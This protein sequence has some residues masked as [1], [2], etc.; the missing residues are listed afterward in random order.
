MYCKHFQEFVDILTREVVTEATTIPFSKYSQIIFL[1]GGAGSGKNFALNHLL[2]ANGRNLDVDDFKDFLTGEKVKNPD[3][4][5]K[6]KEFTIGSLTRK[7]KE[8][9]EKKK[10]AS[11]ADIQKIEDMV[12]ATNT[13]LSYLQN[14]K[15]LTLSDP[16]NVTILH[17]VA[18]VMFGYGDI[19]NRVAAALRSAYLQKDKSRLGNLVFNITGKDVKDIE[20]LAI[21][22]NSVGYAPE[23]THIV[24]VLDKIDNARIKNS[25]RPR[26]VSDAV[27]K[28]TH[29]GANDTMEMIRKDFDKLNLRKYVDGRVIILFNQKGDSEVVSE[30]PVKPGEDAK[31]KYAKWVERIVI[32][33]EKKGFKTNEE[34]DKELKRSVNT[35]KY[36]PKN[37]VK[38][39]SDFD[40]KYKEMTKVD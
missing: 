27:L 12:E 6:I 24:W 31:I 15:D 1:V 36:Q 5:E 25:E 33:D 10:N 8:L 16:E 37:R 9:E 21:A 18:K 32:K 34:I 20:N 14:N 4:K 17:K 7:L 38:S 13:Y 22:A 35:D 40:K 23:N 39:F 30:Q 11:S 2:S 19:D 28:N 3:K 29:K 26:K